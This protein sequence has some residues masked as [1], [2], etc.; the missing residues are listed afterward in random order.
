M[1]KKIEC[2]IEEVELLDDKGRYVPSVQATC[3][4]C[5][6]MSE[7]FGR[8]EKSIK[9]CMVLLNEDCGQGNYYVPEEE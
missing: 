8:S 9:R 4:E 5:G 1:G 2:K 7:S 3:G 6:E